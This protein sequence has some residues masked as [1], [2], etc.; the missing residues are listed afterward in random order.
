[1]EK[2]KYEKMSI[3]RGKH[4]YGP[5]ERILGRPGIVAGSTIGSFCSIADNLQIIAKGSHMIDW[6][7]TFPFSVK[8]GM[9]VPLHALPPTSPVHI[10]NDV[11]IA[12]NVKIKQGVTVGDGAILATEC[13]VTKDVPPYALVGGNP[14]KIIRYRFN[15]E[16]IAH[17]LK[18]KWW[19]WEDSEIKQIVP[20]LTSGKIDELIETAK[21]MNKL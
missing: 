6:I 13:F 16:Q 20:L 9:K 19:N 11:W 10:G 3:P 4:T 18:M 17:L 7:S 21:T 8:W 1:L 14:A 12:S 2:I 15:E 5:A